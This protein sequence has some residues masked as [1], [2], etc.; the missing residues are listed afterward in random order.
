MTRQSA[1]QFK[2]LHDFVHVVAAEVPAEVPLIRLNVARLF[3]SAL[4]FRMGARVEQIAD[5]FTDVDLRDLSLEYAA[6]LDGE[7]LNGWFLEALERHE[8][9]ARKLLAGLAT[10]PAVASLVA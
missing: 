9:A 3:A 8:P 6:L 5:L 10:G 1:P 2:S 7:K 4:L